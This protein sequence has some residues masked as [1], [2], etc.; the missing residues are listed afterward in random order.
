MSN[1][2]LVDVITNMSKSVLVDVIMCFPN[3]YLFCYGTGEWRY[4]T[5][6]RVNYRLPP[7]IKL[8]DKPVSNYLYI[9]LNTVRPNVSLICVENTC[10]CVVFSCGRNL[11]Q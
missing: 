4:V 6:G 3:Q 1:S 5:F 10:Y 8:T 9:S 7:N 2:V 11:P